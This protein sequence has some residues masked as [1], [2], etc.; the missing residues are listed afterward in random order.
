MTQ[1]ERGANATTLRNEIFSSSENFSIGHRNVSS[2]TN[3]PRAA[4]CSLT[5]RLQSIIEALLI[6]H[7]LLIRF[8]VAVDI[9]EDARVRLHRQRVQDTLVPYGF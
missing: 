2:G 3:R 6:L 5:I 9:P 7:F 4:A 8:Q 1:G